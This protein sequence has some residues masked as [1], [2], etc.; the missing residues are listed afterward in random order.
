MISQDNAVTL[1]PTNLVS[2]PGLL[3][4]PRPMCCPRRH[5]EDKDLMRLKWPLIWY[6]LLNF[7]KFTRTKIL[8]TRTMINKIMQ[9]MVNRGI[10]MHIQAF[11]IWTSVI[12]ISKSAYQ[13]SVRTMDS[14]CLGHPGLQSSVAIASKK[15][16]LTSILS[17]RY[18]SRNHGR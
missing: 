18:P 16:A 14:V 1:P 10:N 17:W 11:V 7:Q 15:P 13:H 2:D 6:P 4:R 8:F 3:G 9:M 5:G 12:H